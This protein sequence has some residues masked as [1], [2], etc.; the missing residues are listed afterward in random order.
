MAFNKCDRQFKPP[1]GSI[2][3]E[4]HPSDHAQHWSPFHDGSNRLTR[5]RYPLLQAMMRALLVVVLDE[6]PEH[7]F[8]VT[9]PEDEQVVEEFAACCAH[10]SL[11][12]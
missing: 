3:A 7:V 9:L 2:R 1:D 4:R 6:L 11:G 10:K 8:Q 12:E 5:P